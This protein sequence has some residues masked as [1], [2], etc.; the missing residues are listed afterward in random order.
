M[1]RKLLVV[2]E[3]EAVIAIVAEAK[4]RGYCAIG[5]TDPMEVPRRVRDQRPDVVLIELRLGKHDG[6]DVLARLK[7]DPETDASA[8]IV[9]STLDDPHTIELCR[10]YGASDFVLRPFTLEDLFRRIELVLRGKGR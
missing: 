2:D 10:N 6:R 8:V 1:Q 4:S 7:S 9:L 3:V 5:T